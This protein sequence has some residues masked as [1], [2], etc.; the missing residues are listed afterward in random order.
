MCVHSGPDL[1]STRIR[2]TGKWEGE[3]LQQVVEYSRRC[4]DHVLPMPASAM[5]STGWTPVLPVPDICFPQP[6]D[7][8]ANCVSSPCLCQKHRISFRAW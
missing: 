2:T 7:E 8:P 5:I 4:E 3:V 6:L 1:V